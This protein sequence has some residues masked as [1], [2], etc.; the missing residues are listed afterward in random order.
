MI[1]KFGDKMYK[2]LPGIVPSTE[3]HSP[4]KQLSSV[5][6]HFCQRCKACDRG[7]CTTSTFSSRPRGEGLNEELEIAVILISLLLRS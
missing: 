7:C 1:Q 5:T 3:A 2:I 6:K 4:S